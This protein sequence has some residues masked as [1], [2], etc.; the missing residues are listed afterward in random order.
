MLSWHDEKANRKRL[1]V[2]YVGE[3]GILAK[4]QYRL[5]DEHRFELVP[6]QDKPAADAT[7]EAP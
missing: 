4:M 5:D 2:G 6:G 7:P 1:V 3:D